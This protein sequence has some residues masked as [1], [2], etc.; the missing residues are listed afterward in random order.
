MSTMTQMR[1]R[2]ARPDDLDAIFNLACMA[3]PGMTTLKPD[4]PALQARLQTA[5]DTVAGTAPLCEQDYL[6]VLEDMGCRRVVG[7]SAIKAAVGLDQ[8]FYSF[9]LGTLVHA[10]R[11][12]GIVNQF[13]TMTISNDM[14]GAAELCSLFLLPQ[15]RTGNNGRLLSK[16]RLL[17]LSMF[18]ER[19]PVRVMAEMRGYRRADGVVPFWDGFM[20]TFFGMAFDKADNLTSEG[21]KAF[22]AELMPRYPIYST[23]LPETVRDVIGK[24]HP[25]TAPARRLLEQEGLCYEGY[26]DIF[27]GGPQLH[28]NIA[29]L[30]AARE[31]QSFRARV[32]D[33][34]G[35]DGDSWLVANPDLQQ[36]SVI[37][38]DHNPS[39]GRLCLSRAEAVALGVGSDAAVAGIRLNPQPARPA[40][41][42]PV[43]FHHESV[44]YA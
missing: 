43:S 41:R 11:E 18:A 16:C 24:V 26:I 9:W 37:V 27:D 23:L 2:L 28:A 36:F 40:P 44:E 1:I 34:P 6:F 4:R 14:T 10:S 42:P 30:R 7:L 15:Y 22:I 32:G 8:P 19:F 33:T 39:Q 29:S 31:L 17:F 5:Q 35:G 12:I 13:E 21:K 38:T 3:G 25:D 20:R